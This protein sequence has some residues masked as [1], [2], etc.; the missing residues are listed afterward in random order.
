ML[1]PTSQEL[2]AELHKLVEGLTDDEKQLWFEHPLSKA[3]ATFFE[4]IRM[5]TFESMEAGVDAAT[6]SALA[7]QARLC[8]DL[9]RFM[10]EI[11]VRGDEEAADAVD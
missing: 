6:A 8:S 4:A 5:K 7:G 10:H 3:L 1:V 9:Y 11:R 2:E